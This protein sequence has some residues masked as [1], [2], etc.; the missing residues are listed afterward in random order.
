MTRDDLLETID[1]L[2]QLAHMMFMATRGTTQ[3]DA[4]REISER[5]GKL[6]R[7][8]GSDGAAAMMDFVGGPGDVEF[9]AAKG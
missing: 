9:P 3:E 2:D 1:L 8:V 6:N 7:R 4:A 5:I